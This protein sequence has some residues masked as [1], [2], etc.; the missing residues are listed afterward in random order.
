MAKRNTVYIN[1][2]GDISGILKS[3][4]DMETAVNNA[5]LSPDIDMSAMQKEFQKVV[6]YITSELTS[7]K[8]ELDL[9]PNVD[10][11][12]LDKLLG[13]LASVENMVGLTQQEFQKMFASLD[14]KQAAQSAAAFVAIEKSANEAADGV[15]NFGK[16]LSSSIDSSNV[17][18]QRKEIEK[19]VKK[20]QSVLSFDGVKKKYKEKDFV[21][22]E[23]ADITDTLGDN[24]KKIKSAYDAYQKAAK[25]YNQDKSEANK[26]RVREAQTD[27]LK[28]TREAYDIDRLWKYYAD[29]N[30]SKVGYYEYQYS[31][32]KG[33]DQAYKFGIKLLEKENAKYEQQLAERQEILSKLSVDEVGTKKKTKTTVS[34]DA[35][36]NIDTAQ[37]TNKVEGAVDKIE[38]AVKPVEIEV[39]ADVDAPSTS[40]QDIPEVISDAELKERREKVQEAEILATKER[41]LAEKAEEAAR[42]Q[43]EAAEKELAA[44]K[45]KLAAEEQEQKALKAQLENQEL[46]DKL[47]TDNDYVIPVKLKPVPDAADF[48]RQVNEIIAKANVVK[49]DIDVIIKPV[50]KTSITENGLR[51]SVE[52]DIVLDGESKLKFKTDIEEIVKMTQDAIKP[53]SIGLDNLT[54]KQLKAIL[55]ASTQKQLSDE[56]AEKQAKSKEETATQKA[57]GDAYIKDNKE[58]YRIK[59]LLLTA[60][61]EEKEILKKNET[62]L[63]ANLKTIREQITAKSQLT[64]IDADID[65]KN[66]ELDREKELVSLEKKKAKEAERQANAE[67]KAAQELSAKQAKQKGYYDTIMHHNEELLLIEKQKVSANNEELAILKEKESIL[68][69]ERGE[70]LRHIRDEKLKANAVADRAVKEKEA[71][72]YR[73]SEEKRVSKTKGKVSEYKSTDL[74]HAA[75]VLNAMKQSAGNQGTLELAD[76]ALRTLEEVEQKK[77]NIANQK[78]ISEDDFK[79]FKSEADAAYK[80]IK[81]LVDI[82]DKNG[83][84]VKTGVQTAQEATQYYQELE[85]SQSKALSTKIDG[86]KFVATFKE[87]NGTIRTVT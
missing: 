57:L 39:K 16:A 8:N 43:E 82:Y 33:H 70:A 48:A 21:G 37:I 75:T 29:K 54:E 76:K 5:N 13:K 12:G 23:L 65:S 1:F 58:L 18:K 51:P 59:K 19:E 9:H 40:Q 61:G 53:L 42:L 63:K 22:G 11:S 34:V 47:K 60:S 49:N 30:P 41:V 64:R 4:K 36:V 27:L 31:Q 85:K 3:V 56:S 62:A 10:S 32:D 44:A 38:D 84:I 79:T 69:K 50:D 67:A 25:L 72:K 35:D 83:Q 55:D 28:Y 81:P 26:S 46:K 24:A 20:I 77:A 87:A 7:I 71:A 45:K 15:K 14:D 80:T 74:A 86:K 73:E 2:A 66:I 52:V 68:K 78:F 17:T 6:A